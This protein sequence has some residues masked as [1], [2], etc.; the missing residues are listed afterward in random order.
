MTPDPS[1]LED[2]ALHERLTELY[3]LTQVPGAERA[4]TLEYFALRDERARRRAASIDLDE[5]RDSGLVCWVGGTG[6]RR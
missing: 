6:P 1:T 3:P 5:I 4:V 2:D